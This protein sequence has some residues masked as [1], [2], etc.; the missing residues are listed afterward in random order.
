MKVNNNGNWYDSET[1]PIQ[2]QLTES[3]KS[4][5]K[6]MHEDALN[7]ICFPDSMDW[8][9]VKEVLNIKD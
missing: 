9:E 5:I 1:T 8:E 2:V 7:Y 4:N 3:D 6:N